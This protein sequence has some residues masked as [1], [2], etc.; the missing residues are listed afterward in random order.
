MYIIATS[1]KNLLRY[2]TRYIITGLFLTFLTSIF[3]SLLYLYTTIPLY[4][5]G[6]ESECR[7]QIELKFKRELQW[8]GDESIDH[9]V[10]GFNSDGSMDK[11]NTPVYFEKEVF[12][13]IAALPSV[14]DSR[15]EYTADVYSKDGTRLLLYGGTPD[16]MLINTL[17]EIKLDGYKITEGRKNTAGECMVCADYAV[18][19]SIAVG[20]ELTYY[21]EN[22][23][24][25]GSLTVSGLYM[26]YKNDKPY[27]TQYTMWVGS[28]P[29]YIERTRIDK[30]IITDFD[31]AY[32][33]D[34]APHEF[35]D[36]LIWYTIN[37]DLETFRA[38]ADPLIDNETLEFDWNY[39]RYNT[40]VEIPL[41]IVDHVFTF[42][43]I[44][45]A[46]AAVISVV[47]V[48]YSHSERSRDRFILYA[49]GADSNRIT[50]IYTLEMLIFHTLIL[51]VSIP[52]GQPIRNLI[53][54]SNEHL[55]FPGIKYTLNTEFLL[56]LLIFWA[57]N[58]FLVSLISA[59]ILIRRQTIR[60]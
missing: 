24:I 40:L 47:I 56:I 52:I 34:T 55:I 13:N 7:R 1:L 58:A 16:G 28:N 37:T 38:E 54:R 57:V 29:F 41:Q 8:K 46:L 14:A 11:H 25:L 26:P 33:V 22:G 15:I 51:L 21:G 35:N 59:L 2:K 42:M 44:L 60:R 39:S 32:S 5:T 36:Y 19:N 45:W 27:S 50:A 9:T 49:L 43:C 4:I 20:D 30:I 18:E 6:T 10:V 23:D 53:L 12:E 48:I 3:I 17:N 31:T